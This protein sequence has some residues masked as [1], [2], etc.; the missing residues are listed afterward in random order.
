M[1]PN[2]LNR[3]EFLQSAVAIAAVSHL[4]A[5]G[6]AAPD[7][8]GPV[9]DMHLHL[10]PNADGNFNH[11]KGS[12]VAKAVLLTNVNAEDH[13]RQVAAAYPGRFVRFASID[14][15]E[16]DAVLRLREAIRDGAIGLGEIKSHVEAAGPEMPRLYALAAELNVPI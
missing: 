16:P 12:G 11:I 8:G 10:R 7:W 9:L 5:Q 13:A 3:R 2:T 4:R 6:P 15:T 1:A 14:V